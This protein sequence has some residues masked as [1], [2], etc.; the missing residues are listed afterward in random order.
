[1]TGSP[2]QT[3][4]R[5]DARPVVLAAGGTGG[6]MFPADSL[7]RVLANRGVRVI[8]ITDGRGQAFSGELKDIPVYRVRSAAP[9]GGVVRKARAALDLFLGY[10]EA[11][12][13][14][15]AL[16]P[17]VV[18]GFGGYPSVPTVFAATRLRLP[19]VLHEQNAV[20]GRANRLFAKRAAAIATAFPALQ[21]LSG[22][23]PDRVV[24]TGNPVRKPIAALRSDGYA[25][26]DA[27]AP[28]HILVTG[29]S[30]GARVF[31]DLVPAALTKLPEP[32]RARLR[33]SQQSRREVL[34][35]TRRT[36]GAAGV[37]AE[38]LDFFTDMPARLGQ[39]H[40]AICRA[41]ASTVAE[42]ATSG[43]PA[44]LIPYPHAMDDH[45]TANA[46]ALQAAGGGWM[47]PQATLDAAGL[48][49]AIER[50]IDHPRL[51]ADA[52]AA[53]RTL[54]PDQA[55]DR[56]ADLV[57]RTAGLMAPDTGT[58]G[59]GGGGP[60]DAPWRGEAAA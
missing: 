57:L 27:G 28:V 42:L 17:A 1:M 41:G 29:G 20:L 52:A 9:V 54:A 14:L 47:L 33:V 8:L 23:D 13:T 3:L 24:L 25:P 46:Q 38:V 15:R 53:A 40:L 44:I 32:M 2:T 30:Q 31:S 11:R 4:T 16:K 36:L 22:A 43:R 37:Q 7:A 10:G 12:A 45:Q 51:L 19:V 49:R 48:A 39:A 56:L 21:R 6:H 59:G 55:A 58:N 34:D 26:P 18:V 35:Q 50:V 5:A 60:G